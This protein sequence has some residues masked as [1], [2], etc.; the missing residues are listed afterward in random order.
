MYTIFAWTLGIGAGVV[1]CV[2]VLLWM[3]SRGIYE[4]ERDEL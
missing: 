3:L 1:I 2:L 4:I